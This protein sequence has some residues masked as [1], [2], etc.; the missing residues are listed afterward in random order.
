MSATVTECARAARRYAPHTPTRVPH[1]HTHRTP[2]LRLPDSSTPH[3]WDTL[4]EHRQTEKERETGKRDR[5]EKWLA[6]KGFL[7]CLGGGAGGF[8][9]VPLDSRSLRSTST[10]P[11]IYP[12]SQ[13][14]TKSRSGNPASIIANVTQL[15]ALPC[16]HR[17]SL[18]C[19]ASQPARPDTDLGDATSPH[20][21]CRCNISTPHMPSLTHPHTA[22]QAQRGSECV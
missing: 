20:R 12:T 16:T 15:I 19:T 17:V 21:R 10:C 4:Q 9:S 14:V 18:D 6:A 8:W 2:R 5:Q 3:L 7:A 1:A 11:S 13:A 22:T